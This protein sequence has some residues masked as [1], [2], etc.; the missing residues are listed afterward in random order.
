MV[1]LEADFTD[2]K[3]VQV[4][5]EKIA[6][7]TSS[8]DQVIYNAGVFIGFSAITQVGLGALKENIEVNLYGAYTAAVEFSPFVLRS[9]YPNRVFVLVGSTF[10]SITTAKENFDFH[11]AAFGT[12]GINAT[13][14]YDISKVS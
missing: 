5:R 6:A 3:S 13:A 11:N 4:L 7:Q 8:L 1:V 14:V 2:E 10:G 9:N 12:S